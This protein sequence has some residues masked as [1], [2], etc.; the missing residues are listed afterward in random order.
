MINK[1]YYKNK[2]K[3]LKKIFNSENIFVDYD[4]IK[5]H[6]A[7]YKI[8]NDVIILHEN[9]PSTQIKRKTVETFGQEWT[10]LE[11]AGTKWK[12]ILA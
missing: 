8:V 11:F 1:P 10:E 3:V 4:N 6:N 5:I 12:R 9:I 2:I 7:S